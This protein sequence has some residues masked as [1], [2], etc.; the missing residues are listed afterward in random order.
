[1]L[2]ADQLLSLPV[3]PG[4]LGYE[5]V[6]G[7]PVEVSPASF[8]HARLIVRVGYLLEAWVQANGLEGA[9]VSDA[10]FVLG[11][12]HDPER[13]R[14]PDVAY[15]GAATLEANPDPERLMRGVPEL[16][17]EIDLTSGKKPGGQ[18]RIVDYLEAGVPTVWAIDPHSR[19]ATVYRPDGAARLLRVPEALEGAEVLP[20][21]RIELGSLF[22]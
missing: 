14:A 8:V 21:L 9:V 18:Q 11:L 7:E 4:L 16:A 19:T 12:S 13:T 10:G 5:L 1:M 20:G 17:V 3:P 22:G 6:M 2:T 15:V